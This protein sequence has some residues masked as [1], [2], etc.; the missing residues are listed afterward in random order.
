MLLRIV[1]ISWHIINDMHYVLNLIFCEICIGE[2]CDGFG[3]DGV[4]LWEEHFS[5][6]LVERLLSRQSRFRSSNT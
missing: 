6:S 1:R 5:L 4:I 2:E 3:L